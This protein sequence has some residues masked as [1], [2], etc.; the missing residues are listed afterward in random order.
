MDRGTGNMKQGRISDSSSWS[1]TP[2]VASFGGMDGLLNS[3][4][5]NTLIY[6]DFNIERPKRKK[7]FHNPFTLG[8]FLRY[9]R[10]PAFD[11]FL[12]TFSP[13]CFLDSGCTQTHEFFN[14]RNAY[15]N[16]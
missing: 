1:D 15:Y 13:L 6:Q 7:F 10:I 16:I 8:Q 11:L 3:L 5:T 4:K 14:V 9:L 12:T 2:S